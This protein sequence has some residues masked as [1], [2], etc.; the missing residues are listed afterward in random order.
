M[1]LV[2]DHQRRERRNLIH[3][4]DRQWLRSGFGVA[5]LAAALAATALAP[6]RRLKPRPIAGGLFGGVTRAAADPL[7]Q[8]CQFGSQGGE[9]VTEFVDLL[10]LSKNQ[11]SGSTRPRRAAPFWNFGRW[12][13]HHRNSLSEMQAGF[14]QLQSVQRSKSMPWH[15]TLLT[16]IVWK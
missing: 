3:P 7:P 11:L 15:P 9:L 16:D 13:A 14:R 4:L 10:M 6:L 5:L 12:R 1:Q 8:A 2:L